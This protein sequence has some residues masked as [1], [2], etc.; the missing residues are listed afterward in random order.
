M[1]HCPQTRTA[2]IIWSSKRWL[3]EENG[4]PISEEHHPMV[5]RHLQAKEGPQERPE[6][7]YQSGQSVSLSYFSTQVSVLRCLIHQC[8]LSR[9]AQSYLFLPCI[10]LHIPLYSSPLP[11]PPPN[12]IVWL[13]LQAPCVSAP[14]ELELFY[15]NLYHILLCYL[16]A[17]TLLSLFWWYNSLYYVFFLLNFLSFQS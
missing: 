9:A 17:K 11:S 12:N 6:R 8:H 13:G 10:T 7:T 5:G 3:R 16:L 14:W 2:S 15:F 4:Q 1:K